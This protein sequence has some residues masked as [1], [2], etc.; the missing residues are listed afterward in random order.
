MNALLVERLAGVAVIVFRSIS[1]S[2]VMLVITTA[3]CSIEF[4]CDLL[5]VGGTDD[6]NQNWSSWS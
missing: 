5:L 2:V 3:V 1:C 6:Y 4:L